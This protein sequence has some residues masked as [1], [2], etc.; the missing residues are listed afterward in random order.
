MDLKKIFT[1]L[2]VVGILVALY[3]GFT[4]FSSNT[5]DFATP[6]T[7]IAVLLCIIII[8]IGCILDAIHK[9]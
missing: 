9:K 3:V 2:G 8:E 4:S 6:F 1:A 5:D 7:V